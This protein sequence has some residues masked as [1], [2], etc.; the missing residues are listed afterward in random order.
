MHIALCPDFPP[1]PITNRRSSPYWKIIHTKKKNSHAPQNYYLKKLIFA[2]PRIYCYTPFFIAVLSKSED[3]TLTWTV[4]APQNYPHMFI[5]FPQN[6][7]DFL[8][9][10]I[11][12]APNTVPSV[13]LINRI[14]GHGMRSMC[15]TWSH[16]NVVTRHE[17]TYRSTPRK[18][19]A[20]SESTIMSIAENTHITIALTFNAIIP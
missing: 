5:P 10:A 17:I 1:P 19:H 8:H 16:Q 9:C 18:Y 2:T 20:L 3:P 13:S 7:P 4:T 15:L 6:F 12:S 11:H 14:D